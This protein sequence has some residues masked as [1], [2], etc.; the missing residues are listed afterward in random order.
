MGFSSGFPL[1]RRSG[2]EAPRCRG[3]CRQLLGEAAMSRKA[4]QT[5]PA[6][7]WTFT[8]VLS[9]VRELTGEVEDALF[10][11][12]CDDAL[13]GSRDAAVYLDFDRQAPS[14]RDAVLSAIAGVETAGLG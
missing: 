6:Q 9:G 2:Q 7:T 5:E 11:A 3:A 10:E 4:K 8:L 13:L 1:F 12:G 14:F